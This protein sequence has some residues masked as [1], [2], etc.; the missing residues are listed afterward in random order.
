MNRS[1]E[2]P[3]CWLSGPDPIDHKL[4][5]DCQR[6]RAQ[7][8]Y[9]G[10]DWF[11]TEQEYIKL[12]REDDRYKRKGRTTGSLCMIRLDIERAWTLDNVDIIERHKHF[13][14][15]HIYKKLKRQMADV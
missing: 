10:E 11:I 13:R 3:N 7:A 1:G 5:T 8:W 2:Y 4:Y 15:T 14:S 9:R 6:A 12:W